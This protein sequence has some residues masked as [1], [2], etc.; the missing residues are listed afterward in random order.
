M[1]AKAGNWSDYQKVITLHNVIRGEARNVLS[2]PESV[3]WSYQKLVEHL[4]MRHGRTK[5]H[6]DVFIELMT[7][8]RKPNQQLASWNDE[9]VKIVNSG[10]LTESE[11]DRLKYMGFVYGLRFQQSLYNKVLGMTKSCTITEAFDRAYHYE[12]EHGSKMPNFT[13]PATINMVGAAEAEAIRLDTEN[14][15]ATPAE[16]LQKFGSKHGFELEEKL[17]HAMS[18]QFEKLGNDLNQRLTQIDNRINNLEQRN[19][20][21][22]FN[23]NNPQNRYRYDERRQMNQNF[24][25][26]RNQDFQSNSYSRNNS[27]GRGRGGA[28][29]NG[30]RSYSE[31][32]EV[33]TQWNNSNRDQNHNQRSGNAELKPQPQR[34]SAA[35]GKGNAQK[36]E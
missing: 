33:A 28:N 3:H 22:G 26:N 16:A 32:R 5:S 20:S 24:N 7:T 30:S 15:N 10:R 1:V 23:F 18:Q 14:G 29:Y 21:T 8:Y 6:G 13:I 31:N 4:E 34:K 17:T 12:V 2:D 9:V 19:S 36:Q 11:Q 27:Y 25:N 35:A